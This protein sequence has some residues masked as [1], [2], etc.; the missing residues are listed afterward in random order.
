[1]KFQCE[2]AHGF[3]DKARTILERLPPADRKA[4]L[5]AEIMRGVYERILFKIE[6]ADYRVFGPRIHLSTPSKLA[7]AAG[8]WLRGL[9]F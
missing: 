4:L 2:R 5:P 8:V 9:F 7:V 1:M 6:R 3:Y